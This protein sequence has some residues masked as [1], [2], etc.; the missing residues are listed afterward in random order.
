MNE[1]ASDVVRVERRIGATAEVVF[2]YLTSSEKWTLW[3]GRATTI[4][5]RPGGRYRMLAPNDGVA[6]GEVVEVVPNQRLVFTWGWEGHP[7]VPPGSSTVTIELTPQGGDATLVTLTHTG[8]PSGETGLHRL[9]WDHYVER[10]SGVAEG[11]DV[12]PDPG[13]RPPG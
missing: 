12:G 2:G 5:A 13:L 11:R 1:F 10:L 9:G 7:D 4:D 6:S 3:Q 8:L